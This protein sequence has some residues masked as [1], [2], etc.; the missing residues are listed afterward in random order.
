MRKRYKIGICG[1]FSKQL[2]GIGGQNIKTEQITNDLINLY[3]KSKI[4]IADTSIGKIKLF[5]KC[6][7]V[8]KS[9]EHVIIIAAQNGVKVLIPLYVILSKIFNIKI[10]YIVVGAWICDAIG[11]NYILRKTIPM[12][13]HIYPQTKILKNKLVS[14]YSLKNVVVMHNYKEIKPIGLE[15]IDK[16][17]GQVYKLCCVSRIEE[18][19][20]IS[21]AIKIVS[22][23]NETQS[24]LKVIL[25]IYGPIKDDYEEEFRELVNKYGYVNYCGII[26][27]NETIKFVKNYYLLL[28]PT[29]YFTEGIPGT[30]LDA[31]FSGVPVL[32]SRWESCNEIIKEHITGFSYLFGDMGDFHN[33]LL[34]LLNNDELV[35]KMKKK[36]IDE[37]KKYTKDEALK[38]I[39]NYLNE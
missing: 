33:K 34:Y 8:A 22:K 5:Y 37:S 15:H 9:C 30:I 18:K 4:E 11:G 10:H 39:I 29:K 28:F 13:H 3:G 1:N 20:G 36:C 19:K 25:D 27:P 26:E 17:S 24:E 12:V 14:Q 38:P 2:R 31:F 6:L 16:H 35:Y 7:S 23:I 21:D 32:A